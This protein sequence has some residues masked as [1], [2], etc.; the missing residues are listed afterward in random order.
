MIHVEPKRRGGDERHDRDAQARLAECVGLSAAI[1]LKVISQSIVPLARPVPATLIGS[2][3]VEEIAASARGLEPEVIVVNT[4]LS[5]VQQRNL[6]KAWNAKVLDR[7]A[8]G[9]AFRAVSDDADTAE[10]MGIDNRKLYALALGIAMIFTAIAGVLFGIRTIFAPLAG[11]IRLILVST[12]SSL[13]R[14]K[15]R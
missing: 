12:A 2:G 4:N 9:R 7:T 8:L 6:E 14:Q 5:P 15:I 11:P 10:L 3:K 13:L 1:G